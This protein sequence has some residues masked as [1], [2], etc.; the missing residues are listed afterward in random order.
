MQKRTLKQRKGYILFSTVIIVTLLLL[1]FS[2]SFTAISM[3]L[4]NARSMEKISQLHSAAYSVA[5]L[6]LKQKQSLNGAFNGM[7]Y[8]TLYQDINGVKTVKV[9]VT[10]TLPAITLYFQATAFDRTEDGK[11]TTVINEWKRVN[12]LS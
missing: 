6:T 3:S 12:S 11:T 4:D 7:N 8:T 1:L 2:T 9:S 5:Q 10:S